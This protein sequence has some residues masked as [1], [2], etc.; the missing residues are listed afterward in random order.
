MVAFILISMKSLPIDFRQLHTT[1]KLN[2]A[3]N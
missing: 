1:M 3:L 2:I